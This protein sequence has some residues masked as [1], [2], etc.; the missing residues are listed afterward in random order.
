MT[1]I[2]PTLNTLQPEDI[3]QLNAAI[4]HTDAMFVA[5][6]A[7]RPMS[8]CVPG[9]RETLFYPAEWAA[10]DDAAQ[11]AAERRA[12]LAELIIANDQSAVDY[13][14]ET[15]VILGQYEGYE[16]VPYYRAFE[17]K[18]WQTLRDYHYDRARHADDIVEFFHEL[19]LAAAMREMEAA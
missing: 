1:P 5:I 17:R 11:L 12:T 8:Y 14:G 2:A 4:E 7:M 18:E 9:E 16:I 19:Q 10:A 13:D 15:V 3:E 6:S